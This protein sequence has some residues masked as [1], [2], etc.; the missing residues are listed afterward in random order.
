MLIELEVILNND[1]KVFVGARRGNRKGVN[2]ETIARV[3]PSNMKY[4]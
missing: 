1:A 3:V 4:T 2:V